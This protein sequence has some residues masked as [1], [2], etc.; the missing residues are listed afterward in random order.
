ITQTINGLPAAVQAEIDLTVET[1]LVEAAEQHTPEQL[2]MIAR[3]LRAALD[4]DGTLVEDHDRQRRRDLRITQ[5]PD[6][7]AH[8][9]FELGAICAEALLTY[10]DTTARPAP[11]QHGDKD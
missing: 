2:G 5:R 10:L 7:S 11:A 9:S 4:Q 1:I 3:D 8:G 6:G